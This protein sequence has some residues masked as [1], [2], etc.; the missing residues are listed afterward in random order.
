MGGTSFH[1]S[2]PITDRLVINK[3]LKKTLLQPVFGN[4]FV[5][6]EVNYVCRGFMN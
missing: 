4:N 6:L 1:W 2:E 3:F 5:F